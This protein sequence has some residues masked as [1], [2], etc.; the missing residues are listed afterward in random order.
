MPDNPIA[1]P[2]QSQP[3]EPMMN[4]KFPIEIARI[5]KN[6]SAKECVRVSLTE[7]DT[8]TL[9]HIRV[10][11]TGPDGKEHSTQ[12]GIAMAVRKLPELAAAINDAL[13]HAR[14]LGLL[15]E[16]QHDGRS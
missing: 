8:R 7:W 3:T 6:K 15:D 5:E 2:A 12:K 9:I 4:A 13:A 14:E 10:Y 1:P 11:V 16:E